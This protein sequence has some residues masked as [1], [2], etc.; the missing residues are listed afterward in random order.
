[1]TR[2]HRKV[3]APGSAGRE[4]LGPGGSA[5]LVTGVIGMLSGRWKL[6]IIFRLFATPVLRFSDLLRDIEAVSHKMLIQHLRELE[7]DGLVVRTD[8]CEQPPRV[9]YQLSDRGKA[10]R[11]PLSAMRDFGRQV[12]AGAVDA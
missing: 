12:S 6:P 11:Q 4:C 8:Y 9:E 5:D 10:L 3:P 7:A 1:M 2:T